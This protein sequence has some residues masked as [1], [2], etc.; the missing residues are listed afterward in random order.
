MPRLSRHLVARMTIAV[1]AVATCGVTQAQPNLP[2]QVPPRFYPLRA[3]YPP[4]MNARFATAAR[5]PLPTDLTFVRLVLPSTGQVEVFAFQPVRAIPL[6]QGWCG[7]AVGQV[8][9][10]KV[11]GLAEFPGVELYPTVEV[12]DRTHPP[13]GREAEFAVPVRF[14]IEEIDEALAGRMVTKVVYV[15]Q[16][17]LAS[18]QPAADNLVTETF[19]PDRNLIAEADLRGRPAVIVRLGARTP[20]PNYPDPEFFGPGAPIALPMGP[21]QVSPKD[22]PPQ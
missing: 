3:D 20:D 18:A 19:A 8:Y 13:P 4:G 1:A 5:P 14:S 16:P 17:Q 10:L 2:S 12:L 15:E 6:P 11:T 7:M 9:R 21:Q 22:L